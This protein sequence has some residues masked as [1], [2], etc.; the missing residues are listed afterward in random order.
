MKVGLPALLAAAAFVIACDSSREPTAPSAR[1]KNSNVISDGAHGG[2]NK[3]FFFLPPLLPSPASDPSFDAG[4][5]NSRLRPSLQVQVCELGTDHLS[6]QGLPTDATSCTS[7][8]PIASF[9]PGSVQ[10]V[11]NP[12]TQVGWWTVFNL[13]ADGFYYVLWNTHATNRLDPSK[14][15]R[16][17]LSIAG[18]S[19]LLGY[20]DVDPMQNLTQWKSTLTGEVIQ[21]VNGSVLPIPFRLENGGGSALCGTS[22]LCNSVTVSNND[23]SGVQ[24][25]TVEGGAGSIAGASFPNGWL[26]ADGPQSVVVTISQV[27]L[28]STDLTTGVESKPCHAG[29]P[30]LQFP[31][32]FNFAT[33]PALQPIPGT[34]AEF[35]KSV[36]VAVCYALSGSSDA[37]EK[38][39]EMYSS[40]PTEPPHALPDASDVGILS[41]AAR[42]CST[43][44]EVI[45]LSGGNSLTRFAYAA[46]RN[47]KTALGQFFGVKTAYAVDLGLGGLT[48]AFSNV[49]PALAATIEPVGATQLSLSGSGTVQPM[50]RILG[51]NHHDGAHQN[52]IGLDGLPVTFTVTSGP[53]ASALS[54]AGQDGGIATRLIAGTSANARNA[55]CTA[56]CASV[57]WAVPSTAGVYTLTASGPALN[58]PVTFTVTV[59]PPST[60]V[61]DGVM[62]PGEWDRAL[63]YDFLASVPGGG[64]TP[65]MLFIQ[66]DARNIYFAVRYARAGVDAGDNRFGFEF[67][68]NNDGLGPAPGDDYFGFQQSPTTVF[69]D[70]YRSGGGESVTDD[71]RP[72][73]AGA[74]HND[75]SASVFEISHPLNS[76]ETGQDFA[77][78]PGSNIG[79]FMYLIIGG[80]TTTYP[81]P[82]ISYAPITITAP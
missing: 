16:I 64:V 21:M 46:W 48:N 26:P 8:L 67:D 73:G 38:F 34:T 37:R 59:S 9:A 77:L 74:F 24:V 42:N 36:T 81:G 32:C 33:T 69:Y 2:A 75:G 55:A 39:A 57:N 44:T 76:G 35:A 58:G 31:G 23:P 52:T 13:P 1:G 25:V 6:A 47:A 54:P 5:F 79:F 65:V 43:S 70:A 78:S 53:A 15:Y 17:K 30:L 51:S 18:A 27:D 71:P 4:K 62:S 66:N 50:V 14:Y 72:D 28:G 82:F 60:V 20:A 61:V 68:T 49:G 80:V 29:L 41:P 56:G 45:T 11:A 22:S 10:L 40:G 19:A 63:T 3:D 12:R 7:G